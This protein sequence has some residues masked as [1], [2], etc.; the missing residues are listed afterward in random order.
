[1]LL[2]HRRTRR[3]VPVGAVQSLLSWLA[4]TVEDHPEF[5]GSL[6]DHTPR[7]WERA[8]AAAY[9]RHSGRLPG[10][11]W[12][13]N[14][15]ALVRRCYQRLWTAY[16]QRPWWQREVWDPALDPRIRDG[17]MNRRATTAS[18]STSFNRSGCGTAP[19]GTSGSPWSPG[20]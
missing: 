16:D 18:T 1:M 8:L 11:G 20:T 12:T 3:R 15:S 5:R 10:K 2:A 19:S 14:T 17:P 4:K 9:A 6:M 13:L 7:A